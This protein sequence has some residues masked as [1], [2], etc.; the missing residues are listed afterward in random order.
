V[1]FFISDIKLKI[2][3]LS[4]LVLDGLKVHLSDLNAQPQ[5]K[6]MTK[7]LHDILHSGS[8]YLDNYSQKIGKG[9]QVD[10]IRLRTIE[11]GIKT[12]TSFYEDIQQKAKFFTEMNPT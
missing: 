6:Q 7:K 2:E 12:V 1:N 9:V 4:Y 11:A 8:A 3:S 10:Q 5:M